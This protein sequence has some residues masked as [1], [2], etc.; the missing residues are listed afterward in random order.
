M[1]LRQLF[2]NDYGQLTADAM[3]E[4]VR[5]YAVKHGV[6]ADTAVRVW[7]SEGGMKF[8]SQVDRRSTRGTY[9]GKEDSW[10]PFQ[11]FL[12]GGLGNEFV[13]AYG[14][15][16]QKLRDY[17]SNKQWVEKMIDFAMYN[18]AKSGWGAWY[19][20]ANVGIGD[21]D[22][23]P[24]NPKY[25]TYE[26]MPVTSPRPQLRPSDDNVTN[27]AIDTDELTPAD[28][29]AGDPYQ[30]DIEVDKDTIDKT[31]TDIIT[32][33]DGSIS[34]PNS[35]VDITTITDPTPTPTVDKDTV[36][37]VVKHVVDNPGITVNPDGS[38]SRPNAVDKDSIDNA[39][40]KALDTSGI[41]I[42]PDGSIIRN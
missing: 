31:V 36:D 1:R 29:P 35:T 23:I 19:G 14:I 25:D 5:K 40:K 38:I 10:G 16:P 17:G 26:P 21:Y 28:S 24:S 42:G 37:T 32:N 33:P 30:P 3:E 15:K 18:A 8:Q 11:L 41:K 9:K 27:P 39:I 22:G 13:K 2:E 12:G 20:A 7:K 34:R 4:L 6:D